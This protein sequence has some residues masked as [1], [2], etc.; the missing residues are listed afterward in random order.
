MYASF[1]DCLL[2]KGD[3]TPRLLSHLTL[4]HFLHLQRF[5]LAALLLTTFISTNL[6]HITMSL[7]E[8]SYGPP[9]RACDSEKLELSSSYK[10]VFESQLDVDDKGKAMFDTYTLGST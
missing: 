2:T 5:S 8:E 6:A 9:H 4:H 10:E 7:P 3:T 1:I